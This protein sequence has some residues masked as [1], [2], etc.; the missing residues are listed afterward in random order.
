[1]QSL[2]HAM[3]LPLPPPPSLPPLPLPRMLIHSLNLMSQ[4][5][6]RRLVPLSCSHHEVFVDDAQIAWFEQQLEAFSGRPIIV[7]THAP[8]MGCG[9]RVS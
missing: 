8:P 5:L 4:P 3:S 1:M 7:F 9:L 2:C 6:D